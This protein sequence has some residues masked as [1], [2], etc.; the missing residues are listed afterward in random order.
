MTFSSSKRRFLKTSLGGA[1]AAATLSAFPPAIR[2][3]LAI[4][5]NNAT[6][7]RTCSTWCC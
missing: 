3:A 5:A 2:R 1:A 7:T 4:D 6:G